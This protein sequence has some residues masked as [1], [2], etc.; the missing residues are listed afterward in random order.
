M[1]ETVTWEGLRELATFRAERG[2]AISFYL[3]LDPSESPTPVA[4]DS[5]INA[6]LDE[7]EKWPGR[8]SLDHGQKE[9][10]DTDLERLRGYF[11]SEFS[12]E[13]AHG[14][15]LFCAG[16][17]GLWVPLPL[18]DRVPDL[19]KVGK[20]CYL[21]PLVP[22]VG[23]GDGVIVAA[24]GRERGD[25]YRLTDGRLE[26]LEEHFD[27]QPGRHDQGGWSQARYQRHIEKLVEDHLKDVAELLD[28][29]VRRRRGTRIVL[30]ASEETRSMLEGQLSHDVQSA[31]IGWTTAEAHAGAPELLEAAKP[32]L[33][34][35]RAEEETAAAERWQE[36][37]GRNG[38]AASGWEKTLEAASD[39][40]VEL[41]LLQEGADHAAWECPRCGRLS[42]EAGDCPLD[43]TPMEES[44][45]GADLAVH[46]T[47][48][49]GGTVREL[50]DRHDLEPVEGIGAL[51]R[52]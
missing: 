5:R 16:L 41:L 39:G 45:Y 25:L 36:E 14:L 47:L 40:R 37:A 1:A 31:V 46:Q 13:G 38:R 35:W 22:L 21:A 20:T 29:Q 8:D 17:D 6:L 34:K 50:Q 2:R 15:A 7:V 23:S 3:D 19:A 26:E 10:L 32:V 49:H 30:V 33:A 44:R 27:E 51:L 12:R 42:A 4:V 11:D 48:A 52:Y 43:G 9:G 28:R 18:S 24:V